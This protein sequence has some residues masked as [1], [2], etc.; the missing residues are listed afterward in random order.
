[1]VRNRRIADRACGGLEIAG[2]NNLV[3]RNETLGNGLATGPFFVLNDFG[4]ALVAG[5]GNRVEEN[6]AGGNVRNGI[7]ILAAATGKVFCRNMVLG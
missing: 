1:M 2:D 7:K 5:T 4:M 6:S 3:R